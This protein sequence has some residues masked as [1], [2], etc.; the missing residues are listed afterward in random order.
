M[1]EAKVRSKHIRS[2]Q[3][4]INLVLPREREYNGC[5]EIKCLLTK[6]G[7]IFVDYSGNE[8]GD[9]TVNGNSVEA[10]RVFSGHRIRI[11]VDLQLKGENIV[12][13]APTNI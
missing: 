11:P 13:L 8:V 7:H 12:K 4:T 5:V 6:P 1:E 9:I 10:A 2:V 3:Y